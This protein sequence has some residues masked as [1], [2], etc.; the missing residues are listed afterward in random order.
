M[1][2]DTKLMTVPVAGTQTWSQ[3]IRWFDASGVNVHTKITHDSGETTIE[4]LHAVATLGA[5]DT[6]L[7]YKGTGAFTGH[8]NDLANSITGGAG[9][10]FLYGGGGNDQIWGG[11]GSNYISGGDGD[12][13]IYGGEGF[14]WIEGGAGA[15]Y[16]DGGGWHGHVLF[17]TS[18]AGVTVNLLTGTGSGGDA[19][20]DTYVNIS[21]VTG[22]AHNDTI[23]GSNGDDWLEGGAG[24][25][26]LYG[27]DGNDQ[28]WGGEGSNY[29][30]GG[31]G[32]DRIYGGEGFDWIEG[33]A[34][35]DYIDGGGWHGHVLFETSSAGVTVNLLTGTGTG[36]D[37]EGDTYVNVGGVTGS[38]HNDTIIGSNGDD[39]LEGGAG[40]DE[41]YGGS[42][43]DQIWGGSGNDKLD[44]GLGSDTM[45]G[46]S[47]DDVY[48]VD[49][50]TDIV[51]ELE[52]AGTDTV[53]TSLSNYTLGA[54]VEN[55]VYTGT[56]AFSGTG[57][58][59]NN[60]ITGGSGNDT[61]SGGAG[62]DTL[63][64][65]AGADTLIGGTGN[66]TYIVDNVGD[67][68]TEASNA[69]T[70]TVRTSLSNYTL[71]ANVENL[72]Y[73]GTAAFSGTGNALNNTITGGSG[74]DTLSGGAGNDTLT[75]G[76]GNDMLDGGAGN[77]RFVYSAIGF[78]ADVISGFAGGTGVADVVS[79][80]TSVFANWQAV[81][82]NSAQVGSD[83]VITLNASDKITLKNFALSNFKS[84]DVTF[85]S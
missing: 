49:N 57:N 18:S 11:E 62:N 68:V 73:T 70:D 13:R 76:A 80:H 51:T 63:D 25:D 24:D 53:R 61:L 19:E 33:G 52:N 31:D 44:G 17:E 7:I 12:D 29:I 50:M 2:P 39:W 36:G 55:L 65:G 41:I 82:S 74:N 45:V 26:F 4:T 23:I 59:L 42:G 67:V 10:D 78:G 54:N 21:A 40:D 27:G 14:D 38:A 1:A 85:Y 69:G 72:V 84:D 64:G 79:F 32:D 71:G 81:L 5:T 56:A 46:D 8:G 15:D 35:A 48:I 20:G 22:S 60:T 28:I 58:A 66:D 77:D 43:N 47:G 6:N 83:T 16:I 30:S 75:G 9:D 37:A 3:Q 34:G